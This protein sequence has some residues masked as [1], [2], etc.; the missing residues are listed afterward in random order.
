MT[1]SWHLTASLISIP[2]TSILLLIQEYNDDIKKIKLSDEANYVTSSE[3]I[4]N[5]FDA[6]FRSIAGGP[7][8]ERI[9]ERRTPFPPR[10]SVFPSLA[11]LIR[12]L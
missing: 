2:S 6:P 12:D 10:Q 3:A 5:Y 8:L 7:C 4:S 11:Y 9:L 1:A